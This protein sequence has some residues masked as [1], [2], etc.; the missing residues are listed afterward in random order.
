MTLNTF[1]IQDL[2][3]EERPRE[4]LM[5]SGADSLSTAEL[6]AILLGS[7][8]K[9]KPVMAL[10]QEIVA[11]FAT[12]KQLSEATVEELCQIK[13]IGHAK[14]IMLKACFTLSQRMARAVEAPQCRIETPKHA[15]Q[16]IRDELENEMRELFCVILLDTKK[17]VITSPIISVGTLSQTLIHPREVFYPAIRHKAASLILVHNHPSGDPTPSKEDIVVTESLIEAGKLMGI[18]VNDHIII[19]RGTFVSLRQRGLDFIG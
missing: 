8:T 7:G 19:G 16:W 1:S 14:A 18:P 6:I 4:R 15:Y 11:H 13:G 2:P 17:E 12:L 9:E 5:S 10:A 3:V